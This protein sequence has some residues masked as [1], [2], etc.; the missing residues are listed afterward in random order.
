[1]KRKKVSSPLGEE[2]KEEKKMGKIDSKSIKGMS[3]DSKESL[4]FE[5]QTHKKE[6]E[7]LNGELRNTQLELE[8]SRNRYADLYDF[9]PTGYFTF[10]KNGL[11]LEVNLKGAKILGVERRFLLNTRFQQY[12]T[13]DSKN[14]FNSFFKQIFET[15]EKQTFELQLV[16]DPM[17][18]VYLHVESIVVKNN[19][20]KVLQCRTAIIDI[21]HRKHSQKTLLES[22]ERFRNLAETASDAIITID[23]EGMIVFVNSAALR[24]FGYTSSEMVY[25]DLVILMPE[26]LKLVRRPKILRCRENGEKHLE[27][28]VVEISGFHK[29][30]KEIPLELSFGE[31]IISGTRFFTGIARDITERKQVDES[32]KNYTKELQFNKDLLEKRAM[33][34]ATLN[35][36]LAGSEKILRYLNTSKDKFFAILSHNLKNPFTVLL[37]LSN[38]L[39]NDINEMDKT[40]TKEIAFKINQSANRIYNTL[41]NLLKWS[42]MQFGK[43]DYQPVKINLNE[44]IEETVNLFA[45][46]LLRKNISIEINLSVTYVTADHHRLE[47]VMQNLISNAIKFTPGNGKVTVTAEEKEEFIE[48]SVSD[49]GI[50]MNKKTLNN[51]FK[52]EHSHSVLGTEGERGTGLGLI[53]CKELISNKG[54]NIWIKSKV[55]IGSDFTFTL[56]KHL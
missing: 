20:S 36:K 10:D 55:G 6:L 54:G 16:N 44:L 43:L 13:P 22:E 37:G 52:I 17:P 5:L 42:M 45:P 14:V 47:A 26:Y 50:G 56:P 41:D 39:E 9:A 12:L 21:T 1:M 51:L 15:S 32:L 46:D 4:I 2:Q 27:W 30:G 48:I 23:E 33:E 31:Y 29:S 11:I 24:I 7:M 34:L 49:T 40:Q 25:K 38:I 3:A 8:E 53:L 18:P 19:K 28:E 35:A